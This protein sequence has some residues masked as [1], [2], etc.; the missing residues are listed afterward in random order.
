MNS[1]KVRFVMF[2][3]IVAVLSVMLG[4]IALIM[5]LSVLNGFEYKL[6]E[7]A[8]RLTAHLTIQTI[9]KSI[10]NFDDPKILSLPNKFKSISKVLP[11][12]NI[13]ALLKSKGNL[14]SVSIRGINVDGFSEIHDYIKNKSFKFADLNDNELIISSVLAS[15]LNVKTGEYLLLFTPRSSNMMDLNDFRASKFKI[16]AIYRSGMRQYDELFV[17]SNYKSVLKQLN[18]VD[19][20]AISLQIYLD[21]AKLGPDLVPKI[22][23]YLGYPY[24]SFTVFDTH[25]QIFSWIELQKEPIPLIL[26]LITLVAALN[27]ITTLL[28][29][30]LEKVNSIGILRTLGMNRLGLIILFVKKGFKLSLIG[31]LTGVI[32]SLLFSILQINFEFIKLNGDIYYLDSLPLVIS[33]IQYLLV[34]LLTIF[35]AVIVSLIP[36]YIT[37]KIEIIKSLRFK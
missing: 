29:L 26:G 36:A 20:Q 24:Y 35:L 16:A 19:N 6:R 2:T 25:Q 9:N 12:V 28:V 10:F 1:G 21:D 5:S 31:T 34:S 17:F 27:I 23:K 15:K 33:P 3:E 13:E 37:T 7:S 30:I 11:S 14:E 8:M 18:M 22:E 4:T 32:V